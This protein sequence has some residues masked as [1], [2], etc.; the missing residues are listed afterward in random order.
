M[1]LLKCTITQ[2]VDGLHEKA[3]TLHLLE[4]HSSLFKLRCSSCGIR[5]KSDYFDLQKMVREDS[6]PP[7]CPKMPIRLTHTAATR[8]I[9]R[10]CPCRFAFGNTIETFVCWP[11]PLFC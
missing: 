4:Y 7:V 9:A 1:G 3:D 8:R 5:F 11:L 10:V 6:L 2:N